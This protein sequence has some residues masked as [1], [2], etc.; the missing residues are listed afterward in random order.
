MQAPP[1]QSQPGTS[2]DAESGFGA[3]ADVESPE[4]LL[5]KWAHSVTPASASKQRK[6]RKVDQRVSTRSDDE[7]SRVFQMLTPQISNSEARKVKPPKPIH[8][9]RWA[10]IDSG[11]QPNVAN[12]RKEFPQ[13]LIRESE[14]QRQGVQYKRAD[15]CLIPNK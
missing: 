5:K 15:G 1:A 14:A 3:E 4:L 12:C 10:M 13:Y 6:L 11:S 8:G 9:K 2:T 7:L